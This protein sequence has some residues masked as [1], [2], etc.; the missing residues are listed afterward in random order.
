MFGTNFTKAKFPSLMKSVYIENKKDEDSGDKK[1]AI[2]K[3][4]PLFRKYFNWDWDAILYSYF[5]VSNNPSCYFS[6]SNNS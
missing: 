3:E 4:H 1:S 5:S 2:N 6:V